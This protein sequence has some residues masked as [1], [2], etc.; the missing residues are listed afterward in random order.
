MHNRSCESTYYT[1]FAATLIALHFVV[2]ALGLYL[3]NQS[4]S[5]IRS[6]EQ[7]DHGTS[8]ICLVVTLATF[9]LVVMI[10]VGLQH[11]NL[12]L[13]VQLINDI[14]LLLVSYAAALFVYA[15]QL[16]N[17]RRNEANNT[18]TTHSN[19]HGG[20]SCFNMSCFSN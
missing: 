10:N 8:T 3:A 4:R 17:F 19:M 12:V 11:Q 14:V 9:C 6:V 13:K 5:Q 18:V 2:G 15:P 16:L 1:E 7:N 20:G